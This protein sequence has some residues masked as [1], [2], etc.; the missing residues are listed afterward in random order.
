[1]KIPTVNINLRELSEI[2]VPRN[3]HSLSRKVE[4][5]SKSD[6]KREDKDPVRD[7]I[8]SIFQS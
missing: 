3:V 7:N 5:T 4:Q 8:E 2:T 1:M 6:E